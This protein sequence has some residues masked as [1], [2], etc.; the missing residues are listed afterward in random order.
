MVAGVNDT[1]QKIEL[2]RI[3]GGKGYPWQLVK[4]NSSADAGT[5]DISAVTSAVGK[6]AKEAAIKALLS[7]RTFVIQPGVTAIQFAIRFPTATPP[8]GAAKILVLGFTETDT[9]FD[10][11]ILTV[12]R[13]TL[14]SSDGCVSLTAPSS[15]N[16]V[17]LSA[18][19][20]HSQPL[21]TSG[22]NTGLVLVPAQIKYA[23]VFINTAY[24]TNA[25]T[26]DIWAKQ[27]SSSVV[28]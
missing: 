9:D 7:N 5:I 27:I 20:T 15:A 2:T 1:Y 24:S 28:I 4:A 22:L 17:I 10:P 19:V 8:T 25:A 26:T 18:T 23:V 3:A 11:H 13:T 16:S 21:Q 12:T 6:P 14:A